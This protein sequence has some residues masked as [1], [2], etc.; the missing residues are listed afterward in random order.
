MS[1]GVIEFETRYVLNLSLSSVIFMVFWMY[2]LALA[3]CSSLTSL[4]FCLLTTMSPVKF[5]SSFSAI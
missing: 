3:I 2:S 4:R 1:A 5:S